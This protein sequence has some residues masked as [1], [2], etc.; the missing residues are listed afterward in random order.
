L[1]PHIGE[2]GPQF[3][4]ELGDMVGQR[5]FQLPL[6]VV[7]GQ[8]QKI[9][10][11]RIFNQLLRQVR[12]R[13]RKRRRKIGDRLAFALVQTA[14]DL[15]G[16]DIATPVVLNGLIYVVERFGDILAS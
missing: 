3:Q 9:K 16:Q 10:V 7:F 2:T 1:T 8:H 11:V 4:Q 5:F 6:V 13:S 14:F 15:V 12:L